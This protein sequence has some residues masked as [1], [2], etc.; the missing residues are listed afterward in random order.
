MNEYYINYLEDENGKFHCLRNF[1]NLDKAIKYAEDH[2]SFIDWN[3]YEFSL[4]NGELTKKCDK[5]SNVFF[6]PKE[7]KQISQ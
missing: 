2:S 7:K 6:Q 1:N 5:E 4:Q 3:I